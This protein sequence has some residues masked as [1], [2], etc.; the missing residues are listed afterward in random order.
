MKALFIWSFLALQ[1]FGANF[2]GHQ[3]LI[4]PAEKA[5]TV[6][7]Q[8]WIGQSYNWSIP[9]KIKWEGSTNGA[10]YTRF[11]L[12]NGQVYNL[13]ISVSGPKELV[14]KD[15]LPHEVDHAVRA[16]ICRSFS[17]RWVGE[18]CSQLF[19]S[20]SHRELAKIRTAHYIK[21]DKAYTTCWNY[22]DLRD[23]YPPQNEVGQFYDTSFTLVEHL[24]M[25]N[26]PKA[27]LDYQTDTAK[28]STDKWKKYFGEP[29]NE[30]YQEWVAYYA[31]PKPYE[32]FVVSDP[33]YCEPCR[34]FNNDRLAGR[35]T[36]VTFKYITA[37]EFTK[38]SGKPV[39]GIPAFYMKGSR[40]VYGYSGVNTLWDT[41]K[42]A[43][44]IPREIAEDVENI[45][46]PT[47]PVTQVP[48]TQ[49]PTPG[50]DDPP[51]PYTQTADEKLRNVEESNRKLQEQVTK[52]SDQIITLVNTIKDSDKKGVDKVIDTAN[53][54][55]K[56]AAET[57]NTVD[58]SKEY[59]D[60]TEE[61]PEEEHPAWMIIL[62][63]IIGAFRKVYLDRKV[64][65]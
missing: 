39:Q 44:S 28:Y 63:A 57:K 21:D 46:K 16:V 11:E 19:E 5:K 2:S 65:K 64:L 23:H 60:A 58:A 53:E 38:L 45:V 54:V 27:I 32:V 24:V 40:P 43:L 12:H 48:V 35:F 3:D 20:E 33:T 7:E 51:K 1:A 6:S 4:E 56:T 14:I 61:T 29:P 30:T 52:L 9:C 17:D 26:S 22:L 37:E 31:D 42:S 49:V 13:G 25:R 59:Q 10:G 62:G 36:G 50:L 55:V 47:A 18:G 34:K 8:F 41:I 15:V